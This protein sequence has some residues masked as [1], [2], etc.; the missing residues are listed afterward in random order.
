MKL[1]RIL[2]KGNRHVRKE[3]NLL[4]DF[5]MEHTLVDNLPGYSKTPQGIIPPRDPDTYLPFSPIVWDDGGTQKMRITPGWVRVPKAIA[6]TN[7]FEI[8]EIHLSPY[9]PRVQGTLIT[10]SDTTGNIISLIAGEE[11]TIYL[12]IPLVRR[13]S[14]IGESEINSNGNV[15]TSVWIKGA[16]LPTETDGILGSPQI[17]GVNTGTTNGHVHTVPDH[18]LV[19]HDHGL[20]GFDHEHIGVV[21]FVNCCY[22]LDEGQLSSLN[23]AMTTQTV[24]ESTELKHTVVMGK[25]T[26]DSVSSVTGYE[27][28]Q[29]GNLDYFPPNY[30]IAGNSTG[31]EINSTS[32]DALD[33]SINPHGPPP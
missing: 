1:K 19:D 5:V 3:L 9:S 11:N 26:L 7:D 13:E 15:G 32:V 30:T 22:H 29:T 25:W 17:A 23:I 10:S 28:Y 18:D 33:G 4:W 31:H 14:I 27:W 6:T 2:T 24:P 16:V 8:P 21:S 12:E 20:T